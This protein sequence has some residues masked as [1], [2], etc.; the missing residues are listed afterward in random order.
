MA[1]WMVPVFGMIQ[2]AAA[3][4]TTNTALRYVGIFQWEARGVSNGEATT[5]YTI[6][7]TC[8]DP[9]TAWE[10]EH[11]AVEAWCIQFA[12]KPC[13]NHGNESQAT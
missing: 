12:A 1:N 10:T 5:G 2:R 3:A 6:P 7:V 11:N 9:K 13:S 8:P 4:S